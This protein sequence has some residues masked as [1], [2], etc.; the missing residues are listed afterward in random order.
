MKFN[1]LFIPIFLSFVLILGITQPVVAAVKTSEGISNK[2]FRLHILANSD[3][4]ED[5]NIKLMLKN[6]ILENTQDIIGGKTLDEAIKNAKNNITLQFVEKD[7]QSFI[8]LI[9]LDY[10]TIISSDTSCGF[11]ASGRR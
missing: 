9:H 6:Y 5:Q 3:S 7:K 8:H 11:R 10:V 1:K 4:T 2:V